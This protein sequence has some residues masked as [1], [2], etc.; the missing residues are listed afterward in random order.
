MCRTS[1]IGLGLIGCLLART[2]LH[3]A[4]EPLFSGPQVGEKLTPFKVL[5]VYDQQAGKEVDFV[6]AADGKPLLLIFVHDLTRPSAGLTRALCA[7]M[8]P[9]AAEGLHCGVVWLTADRSQTEQYLKQARQSLNLTTPVGISLDG[10]EG[11]GS[12]GL[13]RKVGLTVLVAKDNKVTANFAL[14]QPAMTDG[15]KILAEVA[16]LTGAKPP[17]LEEFEKLGG[18]RAAMPADR[19]RERLRP[20]IKLDATDEEVQRAAT[21]IDNLVTEDKAMQREL[22]QIAQRVVQSGNLKNYG[23]PSA[24]EHIKRWAEKYGP[25]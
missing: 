23:T 1:W 10:V 18:G 8:Q 17:T 4:D 7:Y 6:A 14:V 19:L 15:P 21:S 25:K 5:G 22:G 9:R 13:N 2:L 24:Q 11:P 3:A 16:K 12:Y 20:V